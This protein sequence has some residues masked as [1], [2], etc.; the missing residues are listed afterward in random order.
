MTRGY[1]LD[2]NILSLWFNDKDEPGHSNIIRHVAALPETDFLSTSAIVLGEIE[3]GHR[4]VSPDPGFPIQQRYRRFVA[5][6]VPIIFEVGKATCLYYG[7]LRAKLFEKF[8]PKKKR[9]K[10]ARPEQL[11]DPTTALELG[12]DENDLWLAAQAVERNLVLVTHDRMKHIQEVLSGDLT[13]T[14]EDWAA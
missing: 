5:D 9:R 10:K 14:I 12:I 2:T 7:P 13:L 4:A 11:K 3:Y 8:A 6:I 1:L